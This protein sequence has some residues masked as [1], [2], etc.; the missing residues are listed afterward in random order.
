MNS[1]LFLMGLLTLS[2]FGHALP[3]FNPQRCAADNLAQWANGAPLSGTARG[4]NEW[5][6]TCSPAIYRVAYPGGN[7]FE[8]GSD[9]RAYVTYG[10]ITQAET[11]NHDIEFDFGPWRAPTT[12]VSSP[13]NAAC[14]VPP[15]YDLVGYCTSGCVTPDQEVETPD[16]AKAILQMSQNSAKEVSV[17]ARAM[18]DSIKLEKFG[19]RRYVKDLADAKQQLVVVTTSSGKQLKLSKN[20]PM[21]TSDFKMKNAENLKIGD[22]LVS[23][24]GQTEAIT[25]VETMEYFGKVY[26]LVVDTDEL[27]KSTYVVQG[28]VSGDK[29]YQDLSVSEMNRQALR[30]V[31]AK[32]NR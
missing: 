25:S 11:A 12:P 24:S 9:R 18:D 2:Q 4:R 19:V 26:N 28:F 30:R 32:L 7:E 22:L 1:K 27:E 13:D 10:I 31:A 14:Q 3:R 20:H 16:G 17:P 29:K 21:L 5:L 6:K 15:I 8:P 23:A